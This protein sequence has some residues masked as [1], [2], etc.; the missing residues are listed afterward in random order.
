M[1]SVFFYHFSLQI[2]IT[3]M[4]VDL[5]ISFPEVSSAPPTPLPCFYPHSKWAAIGPVQVGVRSKD[6][7]TQRSHPNKAVDVV[8]TKLFRSL[9]AGERSTD[10]DSLVFPSSSALAIPVWRV[11]FLPLRR[12]GSGLLCGH[13]RRGMPQRLIYFSADP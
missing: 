6:H 13:G 4:Y 11:R 12:L 8:P 7:S 9:F 1:G 10:V 2:T 5:S 3:N